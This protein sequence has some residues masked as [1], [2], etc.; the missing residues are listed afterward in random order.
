MIQFGECGRADVSLLG[1]A[2]PA[3]ADWYAVQV[4]TGREQRVADAIR[5]RLGLQ[6]FLPT[7]KCR[8]RWSDRVRDFERPLFA[9][10]VFTRCERRLCREI[11]RSPGVLRIVGNGAAVPDAEIERVQQLVSAGAGVMPWAFQAGDPV[12]VEWGPLRGVEGVIVRVRDVWRIVVSIELLGR[13]IAAEVNPGWLRR[14]A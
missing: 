9:G 8:T 3:P 7:Y 4:H 14:V 13:S 12:R 6:L 11:S 5:G 10:Y 1:E 2:Y